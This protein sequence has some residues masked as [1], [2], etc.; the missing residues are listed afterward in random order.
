MLGNTLEY[1]RND[2]CSLETSQRDTR[3]VLR[4][5]WSISLLGKVDVLLAQKLLA[6]AKSDVVE[7]KKPFT[8]MLQVEKSV[9]GVPC[10]VMDKMAS[11]CSGANKLLVMVCQPIR[12]DELLRLKDHKGKVIS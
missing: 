12:E 5:S 7:A 3:R 11:A 2:V 9:F 6:E 1:L 8:Q 10:G 4:E